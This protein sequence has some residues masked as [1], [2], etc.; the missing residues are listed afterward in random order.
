MRLEEQCERLRIYVS[1][2]DKYK[3]KL[4][5][6]HIMEQAKALGLAGYS[7]FRGVAGYANGERMRMDILADVGSDMPIVIE[8]ID[9]AERIAMIAPLISQVVTKGLVT[10]ETVRVVRYGAHELQG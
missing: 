4:I 5:Y 3:G 9:E 7:V 10:I 2:H 8:I 1:E 6:K